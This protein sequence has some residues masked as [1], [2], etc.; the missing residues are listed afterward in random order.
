MPATVILDILSGLPNPQW[1]LA[2]NLAKQICDYIIGAQPVPNTRPGP[3]HGLGYRGL[4]VNLPDCQA[5]ET[6]MR[7][8]NGFIEL[9]DTIIRDEDKYFEHLLLESAGDSVNGTLIEEARK[10]LN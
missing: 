7:V 1:D 6:T 2:P 3:V 5:V 8:F 9:D 4:L 10:A